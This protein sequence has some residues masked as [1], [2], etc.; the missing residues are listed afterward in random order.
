MED[1]TYDMAGSGSCWF[2]ENLALRRAKV[3]AVV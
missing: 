1:M 2:D 3:N